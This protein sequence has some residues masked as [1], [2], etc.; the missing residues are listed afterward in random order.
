MQECQWSWLVFQIFQEIYYFIQLNLFCCQSFKKLP[1]WIK[2]NAQS[3]SPRQALSPNQ[4]CLSCLSSISFLFFC[5]KACLHGLYYFHPSLK[6]DIICKT[7]FLNFSKFD[8]FILPKNRT[9]TIIFREM[10]HSGKCRS[11]WNNRQRG[12]TYHF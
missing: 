5:S 12:M 8:A 3:N 4:T 1:Y 2:N 7:R 10:F 9:G 11:P 6:R